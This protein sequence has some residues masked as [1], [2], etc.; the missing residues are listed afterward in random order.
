[1]IGLKPPRILHSEEPV[2]SDEARKN[3]LSGSI[4]SVIV[5]AKG[6]PTRVHI[7][8]SAATRVDKTLQPAALKMDQSAVEAVKKYRFAPATCRGR[9]VPYELQINAS[10]DLF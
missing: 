2:V 1:M 10:V 4:V 8:H 9:D 5:D 6:M 3:R 7:V